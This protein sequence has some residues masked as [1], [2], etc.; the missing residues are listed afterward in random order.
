MSQPQP[1]LV[2]GP[3]GAG[4]STLAD[5]YL[6]DK[7]PVINP[8][9]IARQINPAMGSDMSS[10]ALQAGRAAIQRQQ[11]CLKQQVSF[12]IETTLTG[13]RELRLMRA[14]RAQGY[15]INLVFVGIDGPDMSA[16][17]IASRVQSGGH[18]VK[19]RDV[20]RRYP[21][22]LANLDSALKLADRGF[23]LDNSYSKRRLLLSIE[24]GITKFQSKNMPN[25]A[26]CAIS[27][28]LLHAMGQA[29]RG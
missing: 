3:N 28:D 7:L 19:A 23:V 26:A 5:R 12:A 22:S 20:S 25:W 15:K 2:A 16:F 9:N 27:E 29:P 6:K 1:W 13:K 8:D 10:V 17:R 4:K 11:A 24:R 21:R 14:A 18:H